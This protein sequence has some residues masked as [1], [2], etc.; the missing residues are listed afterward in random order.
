M[1]IWSDG[2]SRVR[3]VSIGWIT[4]GSVGFMA[5]ETYDS[6]MRGIAEAK[7]NLGRFLDA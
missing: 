6:I 5:A 4:A 2:T 7:C 1:V 3:W